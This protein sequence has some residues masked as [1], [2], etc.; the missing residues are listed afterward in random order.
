LPTIVAEGLENLEVLLRL[1]RT[2]GD[3]L[4]AACQESC[5]QAWAVFD[6]L[7]VKYGSVYGIAEG[8]LRVLR[9]GLTLFGPAALPITPT[10]LN[11]MS[12]GF[13]ATGFPSYLWMAGKIV[14]Q[15]GDQKDQ[16]LRVSMQELYERSTRKIVS[17]LQTKSAGDIP[18]GNTTL[19]MTV[20]WF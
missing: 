17:L 16:A 14:S 4:P 1:V 15:Y 13:G 19:L 3:E 20:L 2:F 9:H 7:L 18:D 5:P 12:Q 8:S 10:A 6:N 11:R